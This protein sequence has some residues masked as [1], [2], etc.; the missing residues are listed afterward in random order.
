MLETASTV[1]SKV[2]TPLVTTVIPGA[3]AIWPAAAWVFGNDTVVSD[4]VKAN[5]AVAG[6]VLLALM[7]VAGIVLEIVGTFI[8]AWISDSILAWNF[9]QFTNTWNNYLRLAFKV[10]P[11]GQRYLRTRVIVLKFELGAGLA[12]LL[13]GLGTH[14]FFGTRQ[15]IFDIP[16]PWFCIASYVLG[17]F[18]LV[19]SFMSSVNLHHTRANLIKDIKVIGT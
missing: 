8:E 13:Q 10:E 11:V 2:F 7:V 17:G 5:P 12:F 1:N 9:P 3:I 4:F 14:H 15:Q 6:L 18:L 16:L 19:A